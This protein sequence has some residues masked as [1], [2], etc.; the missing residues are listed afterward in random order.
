MLTVYGAPALNNTNGDQV[1]ANYASTYSNL[2][3]SINN[4]DGSNSTNHVWPKV[5]DVISYSDIYTAIITGVN[6]TNQT[7]GDATLNL[8]EQ[9]G[10]SS[11]T[12]IQKFVGW[13]IKGDKDDPNDIGS[14]TVTAWLTPKYNFYTQT[15]FNATTYDN[16]LN[17]VSAYSADKVWAGGSYETSNGHYHD[18][19]E[20]WDGTSWTQQTDDDPGAHASHLYGVKAFSASNIWAVGSYDDT[21][22]STHALVEHSTDG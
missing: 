21:N 15:S 22:Y 1:V 2:F 7:N 12:T 20:Y 17:A 18:L 14:D 5:G 19:I 13:K 6:V 9:N 11:G 8:I 10:L 16:R 3:T 4:Q